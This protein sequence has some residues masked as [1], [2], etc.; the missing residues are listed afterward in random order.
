MKINNIQISN[1]KVFH[2]LQ[3]DFGQKSAVLFGVNGTG[4]ST[5]LSAINYIFRVFLNQMNPVQSKAFEKFTDDMITSG[6]DQLSIH[7]TVHL[8]DYYLLARFYKKPAK[9]QRA[10]F[11]F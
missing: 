11:V 8:K 7:A 9:V 10:L 5:V 1:Y 3:L 6:N 2:D 4:K